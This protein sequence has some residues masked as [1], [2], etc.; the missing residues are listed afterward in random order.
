MNAP[1]IGMTVDRLVGGEWRLD[2]CAQIR[3]DHGDPNKGGRI[4]QGVI[5]WGSDRARH[6]PRGDVWRERA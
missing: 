3:I 6:D 2:W 1:P 5:V 4:E